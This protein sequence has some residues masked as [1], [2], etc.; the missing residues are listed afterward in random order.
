MSRVVE[1]VDAETR[2]A[3][4][5]A[6]VAALT[7]ADLV[8]LPTDTVYGVAADA[9][10]TVAVSDLRQAKGRDRREP[11]PVL[12]GSRRTLDGVATRVSDET[13]D[14]VDAF[15]PGQLT[16]VC[17]AQPS[18][19]WDIGESRGTVALRMPDADLALEVLARTGPLAVTAACR[20]GRV[21]PVTW[22]LAQAELGDAVSLYVAADPAP[23][24]TT[25]V[26]TIVDVTTPTPRVLRH[27]AVSL[28]RL[29][30]VVPRTVDP[31]E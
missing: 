12:V 20:A 3:A 28:E 17:W 23:G 21:A 26:S 6:A 25:A 24:P 10:S 2:S 11:L 16:L 7:R 30:E 15:W 1:V 5:D 4:V 31:G 14:L 27:G 22:E 13:R 29:R 9:F 19:T 18:L 8:V